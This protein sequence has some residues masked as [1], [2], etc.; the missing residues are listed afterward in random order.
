ME[1]KDYY[2]VEGC[3]IVSNAKVYDLKSSVMASKFP[4]TLNPDGCSDE[5]TKRTISLG[6]SKAGHGHDQFLSSIIVNFNLTFSKQAWNELTRYRFIFYC[7]S[8][9]VIHRITR[10][11]IKEQCNEYV[12]DEVIELL[13]KYI[14][15]YNDNPSHD[16]YL[17]VVYNTPTGITLTARLTTNY[18]ALKTVVTQRS[19]H[20]LYEWQEL[21]KWIHT[22]PYFDILTCGVSNEEK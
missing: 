12:T 20:K 10:M 22:L 2:E 11:D 8:Q 7:S 9:S 18:R 19:N 13:N 14:D 6:S 21:C 4:M 3:N 1:L 17:R 5:I 16:N 15:D